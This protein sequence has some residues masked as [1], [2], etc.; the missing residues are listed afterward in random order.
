[1]T[2]C[3]GQTCPLCNRRLL[4]NEDIA[5]CPDCGTPHHRE[6]YKENGSCAN[7]ELH[8]QGFVWSP[9]SPEPLPKSCSN[10]NATND[11]T[12]SFC[13][14][15][16]KPLGAPM[17]L[18]VEND[19]SFMDAISVLEAFNQVTN[20]TE[21]EEIDGIKITDWTTYIGKSAP[22]YLFSF[23]RMDVTKQ[24]VQFCL[25]AMFFAPF[26]FMYRRMWMM[27][28]LAL[29]I[30]I[31]LSVP[32]SLLLLNEVYRIS[33][34]VDVTTLTTFANIASV[35]M[36]AVNTAWGAFAIYLFR[37]SAGKSI[38]KMQQSAKTEEQYHETLAKHAGPCKVVMMVVVGLFVFSFFSQMF[39]L[40]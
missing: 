35:V 23:K 3:T 11:P 36:I 17:P 15:C 8:Q 27:G 32:T 16:G 7:T 14:S 1:M 20:V 31:V 37:K 4:D 9:S 26:Y 29:I 19:K 39:M 10:C 12:S 18:E 30:D 25:S 21:N 6:C 2:D 5:V 33:F 34:G 38:K 40:M 13:S 22:R 28:I 24:K